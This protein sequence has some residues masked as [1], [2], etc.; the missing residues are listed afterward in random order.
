MTN[1]EY[2]SWLENYL[3]YPMTEWESRG[4]LSQEQV[5]TIRAKIDELTAGQP[6]QYFHLSDDKQVWTEL[7]EE[8]FEA[9]A[10]D[11]ARSK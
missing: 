3:G 5:A 11:Q 10:G 6:K 7:S 2:K 9:L 4:P 1:E 8:E